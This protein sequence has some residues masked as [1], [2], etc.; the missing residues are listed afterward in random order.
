M[1]FK[2]K[3]TKA[4]NP[5]NKGGQEISQVIMNYLTGWGKTMKDGFLVLYSHISAG[6]LTEHVL[7]PR[8]ASTFQHLLSSFGSTQCNTSKKHYTSNLMRSLLDSGIHSHWV[9]WVKWSKVP[10]PRKQRQWPMR[11]WTRL[12]RR[13]RGRGTVPCLSNGAK[14]LITSTI[15][16]HN[17]NITVQERM[18]EDAI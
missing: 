8:H 9:R 4:N 1:T 6:P 15:D 2:P 13:M 7:C 11:L 18:N 14:S 16:A 12:R 10:Y 3:T 17:I 5:S